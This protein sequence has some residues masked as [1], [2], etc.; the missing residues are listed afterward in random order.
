MENGC[1]VW[2]TDRPV[3]PLPYWQF[4]GYA[5]EPLTPQQW[6]QLPIVGSASPYAQLLDPSYSPV[7]T[8]PDF[9]VRHAYAPGTRRSSRRGLSTPPLFSPPLN[10][11]LPRI[12]LPV[13]TEAPP[14]SMF[15]GPVPTN[16]SPNYAAPPVLDSTSRALARDAPPLA[17]RLDWRRVSMP[18]S[19]L[20]CNFFGLTAETAGR[21]GVQR[22]NS[23][24]GRPILSRLAGPPTESGSMFTAFHNQL[25]VRHTPSNGEGE[26][27]RT[28]DEG[29]SFVVRLRNGRIKKFPRSDCRVI[30]AVCTPT[31]GPSERALTAASHQ[32]AMTMMLNQQT[33][34]ASALTIGTV[35]GPQSSMSLAQLGTRSLNASVTSATRAPLPSGSQGESDRKRGSLFELL[36]F[37]KN[38]VPPPI[39]T[40]SNTGP[41]P[42]VPIHPTMRGAEQVPAIEEVLQ[43]AQGKGAA[44]NTVPLACA[45]SEPRIRAVDDQTSVETIRLKKYTI[46]E[47][48]EEG[49]FVPV[50]SPECEELQTEASE[51]RQRQDCQLLSQDPKQLLL[52]RHRALEEMERRQQQREEEEVIYAQDAPEATRAP[53]I[54]PPTI[55]KESLVVVPP[56][57]EE[58]DVSRLVQAPGIVLPCISEPPKM[59]IRRPSQARADATKSL[60]YQ[61]SSNSTQTTDDSGIAW[62]SG[63]QQQFKDQLLKQYA[64]TGS[65]QAATAAV[66]GA[67]FPL[68]ETVVPFPFSSLGT[69]QVNRKQAKVL[70]D[71]AD[72][73]ELQPIA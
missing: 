13:G 2:P 9:E 20:H 27:L 3:I 57:D 18:V 4:S 56:R 37:R 26:V 52:D 59:E 22:C 72:K 68:P 41:Q 62:Y 33:G 19:Y 69:P 5:N 17:R 38:N 49:N 55:I 53:G 43:L 23:F 60:V 42:K 7:G 50:F 47:G 15:L 35:P 21:H 61:L 67:G 65:L 48:Q 25:F 36:K 8:Q 70:R 34:L 73:I 66:T 63:L 39:H 64:A 54:A 12:K 10:G 24:A 30:K 51:Q 58:D 11:P 6:A 32:H 46:E 40:K 45:V 29:A 31:K 16:E 44:P 28:E 71:E 14:L 1:V